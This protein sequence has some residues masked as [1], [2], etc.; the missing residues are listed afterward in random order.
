MISSMIGNWDAFQ[1]P[2]YQPIGTLYLIVGIA[3]FLLVTPV[4][5]YYVGKRWYCSWVCGCG[6]LAETA[7]DPFRHLSSKKLGAWKLERWLIHSVMIFVFV[8]TA[9]TIYGYFWNTGEGLRFEHL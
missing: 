9:A 4:I 7:G 8:M 2:S 3:M 1:E 5:T 6:G